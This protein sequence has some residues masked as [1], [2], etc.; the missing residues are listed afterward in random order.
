[1]A[2][3]PDTRDTEAYA[4]VLAACACL[5]LRKATRVVT[6]LYDEALR[7]VGLRSTQ[8]PILVTLAARGA[9]SVTDLAD[10]L[11]LDRTTLIRTL[12]P[13]QRR[14]F[15]EVGLDDGRRTR[16][17]ALTAAGR[18][19]AAAAVPLWAEAQTQVMDG[20]GPKQMREMQGSLSRVVSLLG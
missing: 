10:S 9:L 3:V 6:R 19:A 12:R 1:M 14:G 17:A 18:E 11:V 20:L 4:E 15:I 13:L 5:Q 2:E 16:R 8:M 7:P